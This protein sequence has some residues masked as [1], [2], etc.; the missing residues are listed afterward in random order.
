MSNSTPVCAALTPELA[1]TVDAEASASLCGPAPL[2]PG[3]LRITSAD[4]AGAIS[5]PVAVVTVAEATALALTGPQRTAII[6]LTSGRTRAD[7][8]LAAGVS[9]A[10]LFRWLGKDP[11]FQ[12]AF[13]AWQKD[14]VNTAQAELLA[15]TR[16][17]VATVIN[18]IRNGDAKLAWKLLE[19]HKLT[20]LA[21]PGSTDIDE[22]ERRLAVERKKQDIAVRRERNQVQ[23]D[24]LTTMDGV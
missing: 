24:D 11:G 10:T 4:S 2:E 23:M 12:A 8:A 1:P 13:N 6:A 14:V 15:A 3:Q 7:A 18:A 22:L 21:A 9:R 19:A 5:T 17:A 20:T 16:D